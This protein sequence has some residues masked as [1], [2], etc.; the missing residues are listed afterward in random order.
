MTSLRELKL[1]VSVLPEIG[2]TWVITNLTKLSIKHTKIQFSTLS[3]LILVRSLSIYDIVAGSEDS[4]S[5]V[6]N[7]PHLRKL[8]IEYADHWCPNTASL[9][10]LEKLNIS[11]ATGKECSVSA[12][13]NL[14]CLCDFLG[15]KK[16]E[17]S[18]LT[19]LRSLTVGDRRMDLKSLLPLVS[20]LTS[21]SVE[22]VTSITFITMFTNL[23]RL[24]VK[25]SQSETV[26]DLAPIAHQLTR[27]E[28]LDDF[29]VASQLTNLQ[30]LSFDK[31]PIDLTAFT[32]LTHLEFSDLPPTHSLELLTNLTELHLPLFSGID[33]YTSITKLT[34]L[35]KLYSHTSVPDE[36]VRCLP[37]LTYINH[38]SMDMSTFQGMV[39]N[40]NVLA[41]HQQM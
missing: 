26:F 18:Y 36:I 23:Q 6:L 28:G 38:L 9:F 37:H 12:L 22:T 10:S 25:H 2:Q 3:S 31:V 15:V 33:F 8:Y 27:L 21:L 39:D 1:R 13:T 4:H 35:R 32:S 17:I 14:T 41:E 30:F 29:R 11:T 7:L 16:D 19:N 40:F 20:C 34:N 24:Q 5:S